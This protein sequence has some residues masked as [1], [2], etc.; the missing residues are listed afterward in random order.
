MKHALLNVIR[1]SNDVNPR[2]YVAKKLLLFSNVYPLC[3]NNHE[4]PVKAENLYSIL[5]A[6]YHA[7]RFVVEASRS[8]ACEE[9]DEI[10][11]DRFK[12]IVS[13]RY[14]S[15]KEFEGAYLDFIKSLKSDELIF[16][17]YEALDERMN[18]RKLFVDEED[19]FLVG[20]S[21]TDTFLEG[22]LSKD[23]SKFLD[24]M[25]RVS[26]F[27]QSYRFVNGWTSSAGISCLALMGLR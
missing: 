12:A 25:E 24:P 3:T 19:T 14:A 22:E 13:T 26:R 7:Q 27:L 10:I 17:E 2:T 21:V 20:C 9:D 5:Y 8:E 11:K 23:V 1:Q 16:K 6:K 18:A 4:S 15:K